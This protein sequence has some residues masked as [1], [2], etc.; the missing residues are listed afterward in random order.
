MA[1]FVVFILPTR[2]LRNDQSGTISFSEAKKKPALR[3]LPGHRM[4]RYVLEYF[5][6]PITP[7]VS[8]TLNVPMPEEQKAGKAK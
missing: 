2:K 8:F 1:P 6:F 5:S 3:G 4:H 7:K